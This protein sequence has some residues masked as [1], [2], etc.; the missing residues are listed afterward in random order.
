MNEG[1]ATTHGPEQVTLASVLADG[2]LRAA[3]A[4]HVEAEFCSE[5]LTFVEVVAEWELSF[6]DIAPTARLTRAKRIAQVFIGQGALQEI[7]VSDVVVLHVRQQL[8]DAASDSTRLTDALFYEAKR[9]VV[10][11]LELGPLSRFVE[12]REFKDIVAAA[13]GASH[14][15][16]AV[17]PS[18]STPALTSRAAKSGATDVVVAAN[19]NVS[20]SV[21]GDVDEEGAAAASVVSTFKS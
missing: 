20:E 17:G 15:A 11:L 7:N 13:Q 9:E 3:F 8:A 1:S 6:V 10:Q 5:L 19:V 18:D 16:G 12:T 4:K 14:G 2:K 21:A